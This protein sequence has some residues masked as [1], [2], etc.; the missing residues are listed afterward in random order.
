MIA[1]MPVTPEFIAAVL[2][3][4]DAIL[5]RARQLEQAIE[6]KAQNSV[7]LIVRTRHELSLQQAALMHDWARRAKKVTANDGGVES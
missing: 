3:G 6:F 1:E 5:D 2:D 7:G 4:A